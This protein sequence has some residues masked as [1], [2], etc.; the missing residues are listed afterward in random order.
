MR[1]E[2]HGALKLGDGK[3]WHLVVKNLAVAGW[4]MNKELA[5]AD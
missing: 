1:D 5:R 4:R 3:T 2:E